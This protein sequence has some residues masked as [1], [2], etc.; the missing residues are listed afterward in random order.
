RGVDV[1]RLLRDL[2]LALGREMAEG[3]HVV[4]AVRELHQD[5]AQVAR[6]GEEHLAEVLRLLLLARAEVD[7]PDLGDAVDQAGISLP[8]CSSISGRVASVSSTVSWSSPV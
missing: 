3:P 5:D 8:K 6:H 7:L 1:E 4:R 2:R